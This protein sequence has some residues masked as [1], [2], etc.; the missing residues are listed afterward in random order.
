MAAD[1]SGYVEHIMQVGGAIFVGR[2]ADGGEHGLDAR[3]ESFGE[4][5]SEFKASG[6]AV[7]VHHG[8]QARLVDGNPALVEAANLG[9]VDVDADDLYAH[10]RKT[11]AR[12]QA[13]IARPHYC[14]LHLFTLVGEYSVQN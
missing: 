6:P 14:Y 1:A 4:G 2:R 9:L 3:V 5:S 10:V 7:T 13:H 8:L 12:N 11:G